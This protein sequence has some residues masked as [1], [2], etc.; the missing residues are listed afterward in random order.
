MDGHNLKYENNK[1]DLVIG[2]GILHH[3]DAETALSSIHRVL[4]P[5]GRLIFREPLAD[6][7][8]LKLFRFLTPKARTI[9]ELPFSGK[10]LKKLTNPK[11]WDS[12]NMIYCGLLS[13]PIAIITSLIIP[14]Y[15]N[16]F[17]LKIS[18]NLE[19]KLNKYEFFKPLNQY[20]LIN[21]KKV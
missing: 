1:F 3:L 16:N 17:F 8:L 21:L 14:K 5:G 6:N 11:N 2:N 20:V 18:D 7:P 10:A 13:A 15:P 12:E 9:D 19:C 4:K